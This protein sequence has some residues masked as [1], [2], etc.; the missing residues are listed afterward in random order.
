FVCNPHNGQ[1]DS[2]DD[3]RPADDLQVAAQTV[4]PKS[5]ADHRDRIGARL[6]ILLRTKRSP[7]G[8]SD[9]ADL[10]EVSGHELALNRLANAV[11]S[12]AHKGCFRIECRQG[13]KGLI[14]VA[15]MDVARVTQ[16]LVPLKGGSTLQILP[17]HLPQ[18]T[19]C[20]DGG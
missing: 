10:E 13:D 20:R 17:P 9:S 12:P 3:Q 15:E 19:R 4:L 6:A 2:V 16:A 7:Q 18:F 8:G 11:A 1:A 14:V 5:V